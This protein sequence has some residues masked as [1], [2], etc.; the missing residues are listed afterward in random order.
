[1]VPWGDPRRSRLPAWN[2]SK[3]SERREKNGERASV[4]LGGKTGESTAT[5]DDDDVAEEAR[6]EHR[7]EE[8]AKRVKSAGRRKRAGRSE[9]S[10]YKPPGV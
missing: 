8:R 2:I 1:M 4:W 7:Q 5:G 3:R 6:S 10:D 9:T